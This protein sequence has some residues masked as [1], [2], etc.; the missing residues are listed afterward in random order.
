MNFKKDIQTN[1]TKVFEMKDFHH[2]SDRCEAYIRKV[3]N[4]TYH[5]VMLKHSQEAAAGF[6]L[7]YFPSHGLNHAIKI[8]LNLIPDITKFVN[9]VVHDKKLRD[10]YAIFKSQNN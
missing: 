6:K 4:V 10:H 2:Y 9:L 8:Y 7:Y 3:H 1:K 5:D